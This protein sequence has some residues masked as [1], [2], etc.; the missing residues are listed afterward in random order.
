MIIPFA[1]FFISLQL[2]FL[3]A[4]EQPPYVPTDDITL[5]CGASSGTDGSDGRFWAADKGSK[6]G[7]FEL[8]RNISSAYTA[9]KQ[10]SADAV[11][12]MTAR[13]SSSEFKYTFPVSPGQ[14]F[15]RLHFHPASYGKF[16]RSK[17]FFSVKSGSFT[18]LRNFSASL[19]AA[20]F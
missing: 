1:F 3:I 8:S 11:P 4:S 7:P 20:K 17:A 14:K 12:Y 6:F 9:N 19:F 2:A 16:D 10:G 18:L 15:V 5:D 13:V